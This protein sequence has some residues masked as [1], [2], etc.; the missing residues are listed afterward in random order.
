MTID[1]ILAVSGMPGL[2]KM[3][4][5]RPNGLIVEHLN[6]GR[7][8]FCSS[9]QH[10]F[11]PLGSIAIYTDIDSV[12]LVD[13]LRSIHQKAADHPIPSDRSEQ[14]TWFAHIV[15]DY[16]RDRVHDYEV[17]KLIKWYR[18]LDEMQLLASVLSDEEE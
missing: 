16:N 10:Q 4:A 2:Y 6:D 18:F 12:P 1:E 8:K 9:R 15:P 5:N 11:T 3:V 17:S 14:M 7:R 13:V